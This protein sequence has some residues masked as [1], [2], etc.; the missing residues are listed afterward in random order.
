MFWTRKKE[1]CNKPLW[2]LIVYTNTASITASK[3]NFLNWKNSYLSLKFLLIHRQ[4][5]PCDSITRK[6]M[7]AEKNPLPFNINTCLLQILKYTD[8]LHCIQHT[9]HVLNMLRFNFYLPKKLHH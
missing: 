3:P 1:G 9:A 2:I 6:I 4:V 5:M 8:K 7:L